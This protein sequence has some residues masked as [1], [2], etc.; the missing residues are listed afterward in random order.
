M[1]CSFSINTKFSKSLVPPSSRDIYGEHYNLE[2][3]CPF[4]F[5]KGL[6]VESSRCFGGFCKFDKK[7]FSTV[8]LNSFR[9]LAK[10]F[11]GLLMLL[12]LL[13]LYHQEVFVD[14]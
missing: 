6:G 5:L 13:C 9:K 8:L 7:I 10:S 11:E 12:F 2:E 4:S 14:L 1:I 3:H